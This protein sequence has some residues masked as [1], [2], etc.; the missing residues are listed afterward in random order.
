M[1]EESSEPL[2]MLKKIEN[3]IFDL[4]DKIGEGSFSTVFKGNTLDRNLPV[5]VKKVRINDVKSKIARRLL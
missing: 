2:Q 4:T 1:E 3:Y 5:A